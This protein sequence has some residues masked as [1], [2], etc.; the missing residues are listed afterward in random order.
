[1]GE[2]SAFAAGPF[3]PSLVLGA[4]GNGAGPAVSTGVSSGVLSPVLILVLCVV[5][6]VGTYLLLP[7][8]REGAV[9]KIGGVILLAAGLIFGATLI[10]AVAGAVQGGMSVFFWVFSAITVFCAVRVVTHARPVY[11]ALYFVLSVL[12]TA[13]LFVLLWAEFM[14]AALVIIYAGAIL[15]TYVFVIMLATQSQSAGDAAASSAGEVGAIAEYDRVSREPLVASALGFTIMG[16]LLFVIFEKAPGG[17]LDKYAGAS[18]AAVRAEPVPSAPAWTGSPAV[19]PPGDAPVMT[20]AP[21]A[22][23]PVPTY[24]PGS[25]QALGTYLFKTQLVNLELSGLILTIAM[26]GAI[27]IARRRVA[28][29]KP[30]VGGPVRELKPD[31]GGRVDSSPASVPV[32]GTDNPR[33]KAYPET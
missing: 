4:A 27:L 9:R 15:V 12:A 2:V 24:T 5:A 33:A 21:P 32:Y 28:V 25:P 6:G 31:L 3:A 23:R 7:S 10:R 17:V 29:V 30:A 8:R 18:G 14:A 26:V 19:A 16:V 22:V 20:A 1:M 11:S 13:G